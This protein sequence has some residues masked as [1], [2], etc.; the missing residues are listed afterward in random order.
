MN[1]L[2][3]EPNPAKDNFYEL[4]GVSKHSTE[5]QI[6]YEYRI[7]A[8]ELHPDKNSEPNSASYFQKIQKAKEVLTNPNLRNMYDFWLFSNI[9]VSFEQYL[10]SQK[11]FEECMHWYTNADKTPRMLDSTPD[12]DESF[13]EKNNS[14]KLSSI[15]K[16]FRAYE[17]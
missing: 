11:N 10:D 7:K 9:S 13:M 4:L 2:L 6:L 15:L 16:L 8:R 1:T 14:D 3:S 17:I 12:F 5:D